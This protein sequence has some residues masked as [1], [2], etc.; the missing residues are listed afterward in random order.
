[1]SAELTVG[2]RAPDFRLPSSTGGEAGIADYRGRSRLVLFFVR[3][4]N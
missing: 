4:Y 2:S 3:E 1:M